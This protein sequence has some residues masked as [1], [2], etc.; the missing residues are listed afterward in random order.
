MKGNN[1]HGSEPRFAGT[2]DGRVVEVNPPIQGRSK[3]EF[4]VHAD[5]QMRARGINDAEVIKILRNPQVTGLPTRILRN[6][7]RR[8]RGSKVAVDVVYELGVDRLLIITAILIF[9]K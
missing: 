7:V 4:T 3:I 5:I 8:F 6:R 2:A 1:D 9:L